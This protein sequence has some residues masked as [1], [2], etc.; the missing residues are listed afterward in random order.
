MFCKS[1]RVLPLVSALGLCLT[2]SV[3]AGARTPPQGEAEQPRTHTV[4]INNG[5]RLVQR[6]FVWRNGAWQTCGSGSNWGVSVRAKEVRRRSVVVP[7]VARPGPG[8]VFPDDLL[9]RTEEMRKRLEQLQQLGLMQPPMPGGPE[10]R[11]QSVQE[12]R[13]GAQLSQP[14]ATLV[15]Q[16]DLPKD[17]GMVLE[18]VG[19]NSPVARA[20]MKAQD[21]LLELNGKPVPSKHDQFDKL[22]AGIEADK[23][24]DAVVL[25]KGVKKT[26]KGLS[27]PEAKRGLIREEP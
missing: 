8:F 21:I 24:V 2:G 27:L 4:T 16:L 10:P 14:S 11:T 6:T 20:G 15:D 17:Q 26:V 13:L 3:A 19:P 12:A 1:L 9:K 18:E 7:G 25:R 5:S 23:K 22:L